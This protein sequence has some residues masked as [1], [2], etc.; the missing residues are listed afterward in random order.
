MHLLFLDES[1]R[2]GEDSL[3]ALGGVAVRDG[4]WHRLRDCWLA[5]LGLPE[6]APATIRRPPIHRRAR[7]R[8]PQALP[9]AGPAA[10]GRDEALLSVDP[11]DE[12]DE[13]EDGSLDPD[14]ASDLGYWDEGADD[15]V[16]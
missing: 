5:P 15:E 9:R 14:E 8:R 16:D 2:I 3:F 6:E 7:R 11:D 12:Q 13:I 1:G 4:D 10:A